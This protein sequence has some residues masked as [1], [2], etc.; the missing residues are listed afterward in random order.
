VWHI[1]PVFSSFYCL[2]VTV[3]D[4]ECAF[5]SGGLCTRRAF[6]VMQ[7]AAAAPAQSHLCLAPG[8]PGFLSISVFLFF[9]FSLLGLSLR[10]TLDGSLICLYFVHTCVLA[11][12]LLF[13]WLNY[14]MEWGL[15]GFVG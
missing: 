13:C 15:V 11:G 12:L 1:H 6:V 8:V 10:G 9:P 4:T 5:S 3:W 14:G 2:L 7:V